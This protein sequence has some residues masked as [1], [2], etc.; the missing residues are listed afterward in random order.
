METVDILAIDI[1]TDTIKVFF[2]RQEN[3]NL[4]VHAVGTVPTA[5]FDKGVVTDVKALAKSIK[6]A[7]DCV[8]SATTFSQGHVFLGIGGMGIRSVHCLG[9]V[10]AASAAAIIQKDI[11]RV[12]RAAVLAGVPDEYQ[13]LHVLPRRF[14]VDKR[15]QSEKPL[16]QRGSQLEAEA[17]V[18]V[19]PRQTVDSILSALQAVGITIEGVVA[20]GI[21][22]AQNMLPEINLSRYLFIDL[23]AGTTDIVLYSDGKI[24]DSASLSLGGGYITRDIMQGLDIS[25]EHA[26]EIKR[27][28]AKLTPNLLG[29][30]LILDCNDYGTTDKQI[31]YDFLYNII[32]SRVDEIVHLVY[33][34][35]KASLAGC[36]F[37]EILLTGGCAVMPSIKESIEKVFGV[38]VCII[39]PEQVLLEYSYPYNTACCG[40][41]RHGMKNV[42][43]MQPQN[44]TSWRSLIRRIKK[45]F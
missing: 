21:V 27:Y 20:N 23:G 3:G 31:A 37:E 26:E 43:L 17:Q 45:I 8:F 24:Y 34:Y 30:D 7:V 39:K 13:V 38:K 18:I 19:I 1:G 22:S 14:W 36:D 25:Q 40:I 10:A 5:G 15:E 33:D 28:Y 2:G 32:E 11:D 4:L 12:Y 16:G 6:Q 9:S 42:T 41:I 44:N 35:C 29:Q